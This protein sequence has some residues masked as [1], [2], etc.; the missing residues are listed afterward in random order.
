MECPELIRPAGSLEAPA[1]RMLSPVVVCCEGCQDL[2]GQVFGHQEE[3]QPKRQTH[4]RTSLLDN[5][6]CARPH[7]KKCHKL[8]PQKFAMREKTNATCL[9]VVPLCF[10]SSV[11]FLLVADISARAIG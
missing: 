3:H 8:Q 10:R 9:Q 7:L 4:Q 2:V 5:R 11:V 1:L 6:S